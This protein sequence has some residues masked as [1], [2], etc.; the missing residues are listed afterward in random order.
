M[1][2]D[3]QQETE[4]GA[5]RYSGLPARRRSAG[6]ATSIL[7]VAGF[8]IGSGL[9]VTLGI[10]FPGEANR[11]VDNREQIRALQEENADL[12][13]RRDERKERLRTFRENFQEQELEIRRQYH[14]YKPGDTIFVLPPASGSPESGDQRKP[15]APSTAP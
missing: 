14:L 9:L 6:R 4:T 12:R 15:A 1:S 2:T 13:K 3:L 8:L 7:M 5:A 11:W 10:R